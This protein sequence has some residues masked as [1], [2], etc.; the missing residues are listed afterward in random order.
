MHYPGPLASGLAGEMGAQ[1]S[2]RTVSHRVPE[3]MA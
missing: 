1:D 2:L 3:P